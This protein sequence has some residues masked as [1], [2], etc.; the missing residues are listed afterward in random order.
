MA[1]RDRV[2]ALC[3]EIWEELFDAIASSGCLRRH[4]KS[5]LAYLWARCKTKSM[6][7]ERY[8]GHELAAEAIGISPLAVHAALVGLERKGFVR[9]LVP[10]AGRGRV[11][12]RL[13]AYVLEC[14]YD[15]ARMRKTS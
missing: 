15:R 13:N 12:Y 2:R 3:N 11:A 14:A 6:T 4:E 5:V 9:A 7:S 10:A 8:P 1:K